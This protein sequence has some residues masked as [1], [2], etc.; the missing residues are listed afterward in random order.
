MTHTELIATAM[1]IGALPTPLVPLPQGTRCIHTGATITEGYQYEQG[2]I[3]EPTARVLLGQ[4]PNSKGKMVSAMWNR[5]SIIC[6]ESGTFYWP[7]QSPDSAKREGRIAWRDVL[8]LLW[9]K[10]RGERCVIVATTDVKKAVWDLYAD[11]SVGIGGGV[12]VGAIGRATP[13]VIHV[14]GVMTGTPSG[15]AIRHPSLLRPCRR[16][17]ADLP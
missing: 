17:Y 14:P 6:L 16:F 10:H 12:G 2:Y 4:L 5:G 15:G 3:S 7:M 13:V 9:D 11:K 8:R 1:Q